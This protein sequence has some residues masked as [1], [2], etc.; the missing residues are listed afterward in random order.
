MCKKYKLKSLEISPTAVY[1]M[2]IFMPFFSSILLPFGF[3]IFINF[4][5]SPLFK[6]YQANDWPEYDMKIIS[7]ESKPYFDNIKIPFNK[8]FIN[9]KYKVKNNILKGNEYNFYKNVN[10]GSKINQKITKV[11]VNP[12]NEK[13]SIVL[14]SI[15]YK[16]SFIG[17]LGLFFIF[18][19]GWMLFASMLS[20]NGSAKKNLPPPEIY[21][22]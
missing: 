8:I 1:M 12:K 20:W 19:G 9:Y 4:F 6:Y 10:F 15:S 17:L 3:I 11:H 2:R 18:T 14:T 13:K 16:M 22:L 7:Y 5:M 21:S